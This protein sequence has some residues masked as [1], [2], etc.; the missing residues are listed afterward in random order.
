VPDD[1]LGQCEHVALDRARYER[2]HVRGLH[3]LPRG[4]GAELRELALQPVGVR[5]DRARELDDR[6][7]RELDAGQHRSRGDPR[8]H[9][10][11]HQARD[12]FRP[13]SGVADGLRQ[14]GRGRD[15]TGIAL[16]RS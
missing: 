6:R 11:R 8:R 4:E 10:R 7:R 16:R 15:R 14:I 13:T 2:L 3:A 1:R 12:P 5:A 9:L